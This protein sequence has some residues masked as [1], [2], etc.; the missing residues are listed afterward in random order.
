MQYKRITFLIVS[1][2]AAAVGSIALLNR[3]TSHTVPASKNQPP[4]PFFN[5]KALKSNPS[6]ASY[7]NLTEQIAERV[8]EKTFTEDPRY[9][10]A[11]PDDAPLELSVPSPEDVVQDILNQLLEELEKKRKLMKENVTVQQAMTVELYA[12][13]VGDVYIKHLQ[14][15]SDRDEKALRSL[16]LR[17]PQQAERAIPSLNSIGSAYISFAQDLSHIPVPPHLLLPH[18]EF[19]DTYFVVGFALS[20]IRSPNDDPALFVVASKMAEEALPRLNALLTRY[21][22]L[23]QFR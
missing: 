8:A 14:G 12:S 21:T 1:L 18:L 6:P 3:E 9:N 16:N 11:D 23:L 4:P 13:R 15:I 19:M 20:K 7:P 5:N 22:E 10:P 2:V 17:D